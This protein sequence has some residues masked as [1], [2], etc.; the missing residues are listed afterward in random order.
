MDFVVCKIIATEIAK[1]YN[2]NNI[3]TELLKLILDYIPAD[4]DIIKDSFCRVKGYTPNSFIKAFNSLIDKHIIAIDNQN[5]NVSSP[6]E[7]ININ[8]ASKAATRDLV[9]K[10][11]LDCYEC[12]IS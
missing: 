9:V 10:L 2:L 3:E 7:E 6:V 5:T 1:I 12:Y 11:N 4:I 8:N